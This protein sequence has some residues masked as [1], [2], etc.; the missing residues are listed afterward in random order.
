MTQI[1]VTGATGLLGRPLIQ[2]LRG[3]GSMVRA[4]V[5]PEDDPTWLEQCGVSVYQGDICR[6]ETLVEPMRGVDTVF[7]LAAVHGLWRPRQDYYS[8]NVGGTENV[9]QAALASRVRRLVHVSSWAVYGVGL[10]RVVDEGF[11]LRPF[12]DLYTTTKAEGDKLVQ[13]YIASYH[14]PAVIV[15]PGTIFGAGDRVNFGRMA[16]RV[17]NGR[18]IVFGSGRNALPFVHV[19]DVVQ[20]LLLAADHEDAAGRAYNISNDHPLSQEEFWQAIAQAIGARPPGL[21]VPYHALY[22]FASVAERAVSIDHPQRQPLLT[23]LGVKL[24]GTDNRHAI[25]K[26]RDELGYHTRVSVAEGVRLTAEWYLQQQA[27]LG[28]SVGKPESK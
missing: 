20:G 10:G 6:P 11:P 21:H 15:R 4:L 13:R 8:I 18:A 23:R 3:R 19:T 27:L 5:L 26:A 24:F 14:L 1:L 17:R 12:P 22:A 25:N 16:D 9:C 28:S 7:H 2:A